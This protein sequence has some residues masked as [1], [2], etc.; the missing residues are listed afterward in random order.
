ME[1]FDKLASAYEENISLR[2]R[3]RRVILFMAQI[4]MGK[5]PFEKIG[6]MVPTSHLAAFDQFI[7]PALKGRSRIRKERARTIL[8]Y[9]LGVSEELISEFTTYSLW[10][11]RRFVR[12]YSRGNIGELLGPPNRP[13]KHED[14][15]IRDKVFELLHSPPRS[16]GIN[17]TT[18]T[19]SLLRDVMREEG[20]IIGGDG[21]SKIIR[22]EGYVFRKTREVLTSNDP[23]YKEKLMAITR[24]LRRLGPDD[25]FFS[26]DEY[27]PVSVRE[28]VGRKRVRRGEIPTVP[29]FQDSKGHV[30]MIAAL[31]LKTN[32]ITYFYGKNK[33]TDEMINLM[34]L[35]LETY[36]YCR[37]LYFSWDAASWH[38]SKRFLS[39]V[40]DINSKKYR[41]IHGTP[42]V[43]LKP[44]PARAQFLNVIESVFSGLSQS[45]I[46]NSNY[47]SVEEAKEAI[48]GYISERNLHFRK[49]P[50]KAGN[51]IWGKEQVPSY[52]SV[53]HNCKD[54]RFS[55]LSALG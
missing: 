40:K 45:V 10:T 21:I 34:L 35:L 18:W 47:S 54:P 29:Q 5:I 33:S 6:H 2:D 44:L 8:F 49:H 52:F 19:I 11:V 30:I 9:A 1:S 32:Q 23:D 42:T 24:T 3:E 36:R 22:S 14:K 20:T 7:L 4:A 39:K 55:R 43:I 37:R 16:H 41:L 31:E 28:R 38:S 48:D 50:K 53:S 26:I 46:Q 13:K 25:M 27:G 12:R 51:K 17:R 15:K